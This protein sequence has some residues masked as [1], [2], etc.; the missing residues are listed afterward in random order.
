[1]TYG[2]FKRVVHNTFDNEDGEIHFS[3]GGIQLLRMYSWSDEELD[4]LEIDSYEEEYYETN[5]GRPDRWF[6]VTVKEA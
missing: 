5:D 2:E 6:F 3:L 1:M 4:K